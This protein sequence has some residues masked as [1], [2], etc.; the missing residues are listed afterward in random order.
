[1]EKFTFNYVPKNVE[2]LKALHQSVLDSPYKSA[3]LAMLLL[4][5]Y[6]N[7]VEST[8]SMLDF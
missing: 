4:C 3:A 6:N 7:N 1:M 8:H 2:E 5:N